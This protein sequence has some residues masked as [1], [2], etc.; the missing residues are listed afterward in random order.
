MSGSRRSSAAW[1][2]ASRP[3]R[4]TPPASRRPSR[5][6]MGPAPGGES[7]WPFP[8]TQSA[9]CYVLALLAVLVCITTLHDS[10]L[11]MTM[12]PHTAGRE[13]RRGDR[14]RQGV[15]GCFR[16]CDLQN[17]GTKLPVSIGAFS[18]R[19]HKTQRSHEAMPVTPHAHHPGTRV[20]LLPNH[21]MYQ[22]CYL[23]YVCSARASRP[24]L[25]SP[26]PRASCTPSLC[27]RLCTSIAK[28]MIV[29]SGGQ[30]L[31]PA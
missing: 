25:T 31:V 5:C 3:P 8:R 26:S 24:L 20:P 7:L 14:R 17:S 27:A 19:R 23:C 11:T 6:A 29:Y 15:P 12:I 18:T 13:R 9:T 28:P 21:N 2:A 4:S 1:R 22:V 10:S 30:C 16:G